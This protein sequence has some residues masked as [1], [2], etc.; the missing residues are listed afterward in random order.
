MGEPLLIRDAAEAFHR[1]RIYAPVG[2]ILLTSGIL[3]LTQVSSQSASTASW[4]WAGTPRISI[5][6]AE[7]SA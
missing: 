7:G 5:P 2:M 4:R 6:S 3:L 1:A